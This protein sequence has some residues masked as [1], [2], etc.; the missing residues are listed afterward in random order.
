MPGNWSQ[1]T[2]AVGFPRGFYHEEPGGGAF[3]G[4]LSPSRKS[5]CRLDPASSQRVEGAQVRSRALPPPKYTGHWPESAEPEFGSADPTFEHCTRR[6]RATVGYTGHRH[7][8]VT[9]THH[10]L[11]F[12]NSCRTAPE[13][14]PAS[15]AHAAQF[16]ARSWDRVDSGEGGY[17]DG[18]H[19]GGALSRAEATD[20]ARATVSSRGEQRGE[21]RGHLHWEDDGPP[22][23][24][25]DTA[26]GEGSSADDSGQVSVTSLDARGRSGVDSMLGTSGAGTHAIGARLN[27]YNG[28]TGYRPRESR[29]GGGRA[30]VTSETVQHVSQQYARAWAAVGG[31]DAVEGLLVKLRNKLVS[32]CSS[33]SAAPESEVRMIVR[34]S[35]SGPVRQGGCAR[36]VSLCG[37]AS[38]CAASHLPPLL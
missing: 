21:I 5:M 32:K 1:N 15:A 10:G 28:V 35:A 4:A 11:T 2:C 7:G 19:A 8:M 20:R 16:V 22:A 14:L 26:W 31:R 27:S 34:V 13:T 18:V 38:A 25:V 3:D 36:A 33:A 17:T 24:R 30:R 9:G 12:A 6:G 23:R 29:T 37:C